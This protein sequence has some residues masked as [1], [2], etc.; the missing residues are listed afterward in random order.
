[1]DIQFLGA[2]ETV[3]GSKT[4]V[5]VG[6]KNLLVDCGLFQGYKNLRLKNWD[7]FPFPPDRIDAV[8]LTHAHLDHSGYLPLLVSEG[9]NG[10]IYCTP[11]TAELLAILLFDS[12]KI[13]EEDAKYANKKGYSKH[14]P[15]K[16]LYTS[17]DVE[18]TLTHV[19][20]IPF[21]QDHELLPGCLA[22]F[23]PAG[24][25]IGSSF[26][27][28]THEHHTLCF[29]GDLGRFSDAVMN[30]PASLPACD[31]LVLESTY[32]D[33]VH[34]EEDP[35]Q[36]MARFILE[37]FKR[38]G[39]VI[40]PAFAVGRTQK[41]V[42]HIINLINH[43]VIPRVPVYMD[44]PM[45]IS[46]SDIFCRYHQ[47]HR[48]SKSMCENFFNKA[49]IAR[50]TQD[51]INIA[52]TANP[53]IVISSSGMAT[54]GRVLHHL[55]R[56]L[57][58]H[59]NA[60]LFTGYQAGGTRGAKLLAGE[61]SIKIHGQFVPIQARVHNVDTMS[62]HADSKELIRWVSESPTPPKRI[63]LNHGEPKALDSL[64]DKLRQKFPETQVEIA[65]E[66]QTLQLTGRSS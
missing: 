48:L 13:Q 39:E 65:K 7:K 55:R 58:D 4:L 49:I 5:H 37:A 33:R 50:S 32:G 21:G 44:S 8:V 10:P 52:S 31:T 47:E 27:T 19:K 63:I 3:T 29:S 25:I 40:I 26:V 41:V 64:R 30:P 59:R 56:A 57:P 34:D 17:E 18:K 1:M 46:A 24:H 23:S 43:G 54:G 36:E 53:K 38:G 11:G 12:A 45:G 62:A 2:A 51:S 60:I 14:K 35:E 16:P 61:P 42:Y 66:S 9:F 20:A 22:K 15:A 6:D 28:L